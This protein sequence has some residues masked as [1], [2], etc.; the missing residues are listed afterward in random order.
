VIFL[1][2]DKIIKYGS[3]TLVAIFILSTLSL[4]F[5][6]SNPSVNPNNSVL[7]GYVIGYAKISS[8]DKVVKV[9]NPTKELEKLLEDLSK[10]GTIVRSFN[11]ENELVIELKDEKDVYRLNKLFNEYN[12]SI[13]AD[14]IID[15]ENLTFFDDSGKQL[16]IP[17]QR[18]K[19]KITP[20]FDIAEPFKIKA[21][22]IVG[23]V[24][25]KEPVVYLLSI[26]L[27]E[28]EKIQIALKP[29]NITLI[30]YAISLK[31][32]WDSRSYIYDLSSKLNQSNI[33]NKVNLANYL[34]FNSTPSNTSLSQLASSNI[35]FISK[36][37]K[38]TISLNNIQTKK[39]EINNLLSLYNI[40]V[41]FPD[42]S[43]EIENLDTKNINFIEGLVSNYSNLNISIQKENLVEV[44]FYQES[45]Y[46]STKYVLDE[47]KL[48]VRFKTALNPNDI[49]NISVQAE[50]VGNKIKDYKIQQ[51]Q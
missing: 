35:P 46:G 10:N 36:I 9:Q 14:A 4:L 33:T 31:I 25:S 50:V 48:K 41:I 42:S 45:E 13:F 49:K 24:S 23:E 12:S 27:L 28:N 29:K 40:N 2:K 39:D 7:Q 20:L 37:T 21:D 1:E 16:S 5:L 3:L 26:S 47:D 51:E 38:S 30:S 11:F 43:I 8:Y 22:A 44:E 18:K 6:N 34:F 19:Q 32:P 15:F 17:N